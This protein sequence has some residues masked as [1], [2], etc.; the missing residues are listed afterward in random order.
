MITNINEIPK[1]ACGIYKIEYENGKIY[2][3]Q[4]INCYVRALEHNSKNKYPC[5]LALKKYQAK[6]IILEDNIA[7][8]DLD[9]KEIEYINLFDSTNKEKGYNILKGGNASN[10]RGTENCNASFNE[11]QLKEII[12]LL[13]N[14]TEYSLLDIANKFNVTQAT[15]LR[16]SLGYSYKQ[17]DLQYPLRNN[18]HDSVKKNEIKDYFPDEQ[19]L[20]NL[21]HD[22]KY[23]WDL[24]LEEDL[25]KK[26]NIPIRIMRDINNGRKFSEYGN[27]EYPIR[28]KNVRNSKNLTIQQIK[29]ILDLLQNSQKSMTEIGKMYNLHRDTISAIN[30]GKSYIIY[31]FSYPARS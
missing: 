13:L 1:D 10:K 28:A 19:T 29:E 14:H 23:R 7:I 15:I 6:M 24:T 17:E 26:Y 25:T 3:G 8:Q 21:K 31:N 22:M 11:I 2:I 12:D 5:D 27:Y 4:A 18:N 20:L 16:I 30:Q 9:K